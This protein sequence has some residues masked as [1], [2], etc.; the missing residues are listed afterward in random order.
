MHLNAI[1]QLC[2]PSR[3]L[4]YELNLHLSRMLTELLTHTHLPGL[5]S[6]DQMHLLAIAD[7][8]SHFSADVV[9]KLTQANAGG[10]SCGLRNILLIDQVSVFWTKKRQVNYVFS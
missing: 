8:L 2:F 6:V 9:D 4:G 5:S 3:S 1:S 7:T 10:Y